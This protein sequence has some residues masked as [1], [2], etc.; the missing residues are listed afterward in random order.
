MS[1]V[2]LVWGSAS[3]AG[4]V[5]PQDTVFRS[6]FLSPELQLMIPGCMSPRPSNFHDDIIAVKCEPDI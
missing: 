6:E 4:M 1:S 5:L 3:E 2:F